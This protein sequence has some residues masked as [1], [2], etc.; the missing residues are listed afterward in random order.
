MLRRRNGDAKRRGIQ[1]TASSRRPLRVSCSDE[2]DEDEEE[3]ED[4]K[5]SNQE[6]DEMLH[7]VREERKQKQVAEDIKAGVGRKDGLAA[8]GDVASDEDEPETAPSSG[9][10]PTDS[11]PEPAVGG[12]AAA[13]PTAS[14]D[15]STDA[16]GPASALVP[17]TAATGSTTVV[18]QSAEETPLPPEGVITAG[19]AQKGPKKRGG[20]AK[21]GSLRR[22]EKAAQDGEE[23]K[24]GEPRRPAK[25]RK[26]DDD[27]DRW[28]KIQLHGEKK[29][30]K[31]DATRVVSYFDHDSRGSM[32][33]RAEESL[34]SDSQG[35][36]STGDSLRA[37]MRSMFEDDD[38]DDEVDEKK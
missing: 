22:K 23:P 17:A 16:T 18:T 25:R 28:I 19:Q 38:D 26:A 1:M 11:R 30:K 4:V 29:P 33:D 3:V 8:Y 2:D 20:V 24:D 13:P 34:G 7:S 36:S 12:D 15:V 21:P 5:A 32:F 10:K 31:I 27:P 37:Q 35:M 6:W 9:G 14:G